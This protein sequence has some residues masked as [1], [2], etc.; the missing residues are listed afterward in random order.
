MSSRRVLGRAAAYISR[1]PV[2]IQGQNGSAA[3]CR[4]CNALT[5]GFCLD[6][7]EAMEV[8]QDWNDIC[9]PPWSEVEL[10]YA[11][12]N[13]II[14]CDHQLDYGHLLDAKR[15]RRRR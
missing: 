14:R 1:C 8:I 2:S 5:H 7:S 9:M 13:S 3:L 10:E 12:R 6:E 15:K 11:I 4:V